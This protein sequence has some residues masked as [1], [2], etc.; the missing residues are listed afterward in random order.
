MN[1]ETLEAI[2]AEW[3]IDLGLGSTT[4][5]LDFTVP[6][7]DG[8]YATVITHSIYD[9]ATITLD[10]AWEEWDEDF[11]DYI[12]L[13]ELLHVLHADVCSAANTVDGM[14]GA[15]AEAFFNA[16]FN[17]A[18]EQFIDRLAHRILEIK[19]L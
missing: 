5:E 10:P 18:V 8:A 17:Y 19:N 7:S 12:M 3:L 4:V 11:A 16:R 6:A 14:L 2:V 1:E 15:P 13:H 9:S